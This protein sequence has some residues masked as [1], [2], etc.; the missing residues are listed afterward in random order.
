M[1]WRWS[2]PADQED[3][4]LR[5]KSKQYEPKIDSL[6]ERAA[7]DE[8]TDFDGLVL[9]IK[10]KLDEEKAEKDAKTAKE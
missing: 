7:V 9:S 6:I 4:A 3:V 5:V 2:S 10:A 8:H 1:A